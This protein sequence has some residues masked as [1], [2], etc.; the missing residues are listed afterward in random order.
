VQ[1]AWWDALDDVVDPL[2]VHSLT[3][4]DDNANAL[5]KVDIAPPTPLSTK[6]EPWPP[7]LRQAVIA[8]THFDYYVTGSP[9]N[10][11]RHFEDP[12]IQLTVTPD[13]TEPFYE[14]PIVFGIAP[15][16]TCYERHHEDQ[17]QWFGVSFYE[18]DTGGELDEWAWDRTNIR[19]FSYDEESD[20]TSHYQTWIEYQPAYWELPSP[21]TGST[22]CLRRPDRDDVGDPPEPREDLFGAAMIQEIIDGT[23]VWVGEGDIIPS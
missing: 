4:G 16:V 2:N 1:Y 13:T 22:L 12:R 11:G 14:V 21:F 18:A 7:P 10:W 5:A 23:T 8:W 19:S 17:D 20:I 3:S 15:Y 9:G 6:P